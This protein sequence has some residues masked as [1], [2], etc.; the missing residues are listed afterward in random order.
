MNV[1][2]LTFILVTCVGIYGLHL[3]RKPG[4]QN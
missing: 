4:K 1:W 2:I 3:T